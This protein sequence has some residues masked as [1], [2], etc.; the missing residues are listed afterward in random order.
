MANRELSQQPGRPNP[1]VSEEN[2]NDPLNHT[3]GANIYQHEGA[4]E[5]WLYFEVRSV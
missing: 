2:Q 5:N 1:S 4:K 3:K